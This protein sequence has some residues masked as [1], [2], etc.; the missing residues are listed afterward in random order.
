MPGPVAVKGDQGE[1]AR[2][3]QQQAARLRDEAESQVGEARGVRHGGRRDDQRR[4]Q[5]QLA[6]A[7]AG[8][9]AGADRTVYEAEGE[10]GAGAAAGGRVRQRCGADGPRRGLERDAQDALCAP[11]Q[12]AADAD[13]RGPA[14]GG[15]R[16]REGRVARARQQAEAQGSEDRQA[17]PAQHLAEG[18]RRERC[19]RAD[20]QAGGELDGG[21]A[22][23]GQRDGIRH[24]QRRGVADASPQAQDSGRGGG[25]RDGE[26][27]TLQGWQPRIGR[28]T[29]QLQREG[30]LPR[31]WRGGG[32]VGRPDF[33]GERRGQDEQPRP[34]E[35][36]AAAGRGLDAHARGGSKER[37]VSARCRGRGA[38]ACAGGAEACGGA[39]ARAP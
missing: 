14:A 32:V 9:A 28:C 34:G 38:E 10:R 29:D 8:A 4:H 18:L 7:G 24:E 31:E 12:Q 22:G 16:N 25:L 23:L 11:E 19:Q 21:E 27:R 1:Q 30:P 39:A 36:P 20:A 17:A 13:G 6:T 5:L 2:A 33:G 15:Q 35:R 3:E 26:A 37:A